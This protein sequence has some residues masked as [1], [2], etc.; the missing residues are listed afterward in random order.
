MKMA[1]HD[2]TYDMWHRACLKE[3]GELAAQAVRVRFKE[4]VCGYAAM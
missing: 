3:Q 2:D 1:P 4:T